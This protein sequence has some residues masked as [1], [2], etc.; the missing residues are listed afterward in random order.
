MSTQMNIRTLVRSPTKLATDKYRQGMSVMFVN[1]VNH[2]LPAFVTGKLGGRQQEDPEEATFGVQWETPPTS[3]EDFLKWYDDIALIMNDL[4]QRDE[5]LIR[6]FVHESRLVAYGCNMREA[7]TL[8][9]GSDAYRGNLKAFGLNMAEY[10]ISKFAA[11][12]HI[13][14]INE[15]T[16]LA[17]ARRVVGDTT[18][19]IPM[20]LYNQVRDEAMNK[21][22]KAIQMEEWITSNP[23]FADSITADK[24]MANINPLLKWIYDHEVN[25]AAT[26]AA[27]A[28]TTTDPT[29]PPKTPAT[30]TMKTPPTVKNTPR[31]Y[32]RAPLTNDPKTARMLDTDMNVHDDSSTEDADEEDDDS[33]DIS[34]TVPME[35][36]TCQSMNKFI[37]LIRQSQFG[38]LKTMDGLDNL[39]L[40]VAYV[41]WLLLLLGRNTITNTKFNTDHDWYSTHSDHRIKFINGYYATWGSKSKMWNQSEAEG[42]K[43]R[44]HLAHNGMVA[45][46]GTLTATAIRLTDENLLRALAEGSNLSIEKVYHLITGRPNYLNADA[47]AVKILTKDKP[48]TFAPAEEGK[49]RL[50]DS[51]IEF[52]PNSTLMKQLRAPSQIMDLRTYD[53]PNELPKTP[54]KKRKV[55]A[56]TR[57]K[58]LPSLQPT[59][60]SRSNDDEEAASQWTQ[61]TEALTA[62][63]TT[64]ER[65]IEIDQTPK[66]QQEAGGHD[67]DDKKPKARGN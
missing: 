13:M 60:R 65:P 44:P 3:N 57:T 47:D 7:V 49:G 26:V 53:I 21:V 50:Y 17:T 5:T 37:Q 46:M 43:Y 31:E 16:L 27:S 42:K 54:T 64:I 58:A 66:P 45:V 34:D 63:L 56:V 19:P 35:L 24:R 32:A 12:R 61:Q 6:E 8:T 62:V 20:G 2:R 59:T 36:P 18:I 39:E 28:T 23:D 67:S 48:G 38:K 29:T 41:T 4:D 10:K 11:R 14:D 52:L 30:D 15:R 51:I 25:T 33:L 1:V 40:M 9:P 22:K 55:A